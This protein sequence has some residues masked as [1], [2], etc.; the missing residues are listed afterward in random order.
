ML[1]VTTWFSAV[2]AFEISVGEEV[3]DS[4]SLRLLIVRGADVEDAREAASRHAK[5]QEVT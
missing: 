1:R 3:G 4:R 2:V 5:A